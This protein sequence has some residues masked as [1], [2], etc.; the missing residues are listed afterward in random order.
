MGQYTHLTEK[1]RV[2]IF[3]G[4]KEGKSRSEI[5][6]EIGKHKSVIGREIK[7]NSSSE[8][9][10]EY[11]PDTAQKKAQER[12]NKQ[13]P[14]L[15]KD[16]ALKAK[17]IDCLKRGWSP[18]IIAGRLKQEQAGNICAESIYA[19]I[20]SKEGMQLKL[21][22]YLLKTRKKRGVLH[23][24]K[25]RKSKI[26]NRTPITERPDEVKMRSSFGHLEIDLLFVNGNKSRNVLVIVE[27]KTRLVLMALNNNKTTTEVMANCLSL[28]KTLP[29]KMRLTATF[30][31]GLEFANHEILIKELNM[32][33]Y[34]CNP[35]SPWEKGQVESV[36]SLIRRLI[37]RNLSLKDLTT[38]LVQRTM[39]FLNNLPRKCLGFKSPLEVF[40]AHFN[41]CCTSC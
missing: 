40:N 15:S 7:R 29:N 41:T 32:K 4:L 39:D 13:K 20:Y 35:H 27:R 10:G 19:F 28:L 21:W 16:E 11:L 33:N 5:G 24:R 6:K 26:P 23:G 8:L 25:A 22:R 30:D 3:N 9:K 2:I 1:D 14:K 38:G 37:P 12:K 31:N 17:V 34:F 18:E 36:N